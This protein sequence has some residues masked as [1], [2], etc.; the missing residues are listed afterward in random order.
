MATS[1]FVHKTHLEIIRLAGLEMII[2]WLR[3]TDIEGNSSTNG[4][5]LLQVLQITNHRLTE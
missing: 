5:K 3:F 2:Q 1:Y 4:E